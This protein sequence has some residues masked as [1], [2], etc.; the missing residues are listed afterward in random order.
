VT[1]QAIGGSQPD[2]LGGLERLMAAVR[3]EFRADVLVFPATDPV[4]G[5]G[6]CRVTG[7]RRAARGHGLCQG[8]H[9]RWAKQG[10]PDLDVFAATTDAG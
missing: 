1:A 6:A 5:G 9:L 2:R 8:H 7:C 4:F 3:P 10:R